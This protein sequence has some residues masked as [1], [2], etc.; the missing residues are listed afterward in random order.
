MS[1]TF[2]ASPVLKIIADLIR[3][4]ADLSNYD[5]F[6]ETITVGDEMLTSIPLTAVLL[7]VTDL[8]LTL[9]DHSAINYGQIAQEAS[10]IVDTK[11][12]TIKRLPHV[13]I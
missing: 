10:L 13:I 6:I 9:I 2:R 3:K 11:I 4:K 1:T 8:V 7:H 12:V 5:P